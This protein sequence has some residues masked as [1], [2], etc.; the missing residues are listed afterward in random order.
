MEKELIKIDR[1]GSKHYKGMCTCDRCNG[2]GVYYIGVHNGKLIPASPDGG[3]CYKCHGKGK[4]LSTWIE[5]T[6]EYQA[7]LDAKREAKN[8][9][10]RAKMEEN[11]RIKREKEEAEKE[12]REKA[13]KERKANLQYI[14]NIGDR[15]KKVPVN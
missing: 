9:A 11:A 15:L 1:N 6:P 13:E 12:A 10:M 4:I 14:G 2:S 3:T 8:A 7:K 5:R